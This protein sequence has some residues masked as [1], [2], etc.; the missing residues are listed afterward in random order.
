MPQNCL[1][2]DERGPRY[3]TGSRSLLTKSSVGPHSTKSPARWAVHLECRQTPWTT[4]PQM[5]KAGSEG[6]LMR[7][8]VRLLSRCPC[9]E[10]SRPEGKEDSNN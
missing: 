6:S 7:D 4:E 9:A 3:L 10:L 1:P 2:R 8:R 5:L